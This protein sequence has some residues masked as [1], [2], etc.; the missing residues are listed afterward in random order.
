MRRSSNDKEKSSNVKFKI[1]TQ[2]SSSKTQKLIKCSNSCK[3]K[4]KYLR[5]KRRFFNWLFEEKHHLRHSTRRLFLTNSRKKRLFIF[6]KYIQV[7]LWQL[8]KVKFCLFRKWK[9]IATNENCVII[10]NF[11]TRVKSLKNI[12]TKKFLIFVSSIWITTST[13]TK[14]SR[15]LREKFNFWAKSR[16]KIYIYLYFFLF[17]FFVLFFFAIL[18]EI[19][20]SIRSRVIRVWLDF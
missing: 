11:N 16:S 14:M 19:F 7:L 9:K 20:Y 1:Q 4:S 15:C 10:A 17:F 12:S 3:S 2:S 13:S 8:F 5:N 18:Q 6:Q